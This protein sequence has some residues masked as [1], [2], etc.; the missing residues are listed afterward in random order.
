MNQINKE[1]EKNFNIDLGPKLSERV[2]F[3]LHL[4]RSRVFLYEKILKRIRPKYVLLVCSYGKEN[5]IEACKNLNITMIELQHGNLDA[6]HIGY[7]FPKNINT[8][9]MFPD[10]FLCFGS[11]WKNQANLPLDES[12]VIEY[13]FPFFEKEVDKIRHLTQENKITFISQGTLGE[14]ISKFAVELSKQPGFDYQII[15]KLHP[16]EVP[17]W[18]INYPWLINEKIQV[19]DSDAPPL[20]QLLATSKFTVGVYSTAIYE[21]IGLKSNTFLLHFPGIEA[22]SPLINGNFVEVVTNPE[23]LFLM[24]SKPARNT[25]HDNIKNVFFKEP[26]RITELL[27]KLS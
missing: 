24:F 13:G 19:I 27:T 23:E 20:Y 2:K 5:F 14:K 22:M 18:K 9:K 12:R 21:A 8:K 4:R 10:Y 11:F 3:I 26:K 16:G 17:N 1:L 6:C 7:H 25:D 15:Y